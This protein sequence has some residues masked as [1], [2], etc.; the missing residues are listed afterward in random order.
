MQIVTLIIHLILC[1]LFVITFDGREIGAA[2]A[3][4]ITYILNMLGLEIYCCF[5]KSVKET[6]T[7]GPDRRAF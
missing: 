1:Y 4:N 3:T 6:Y 7:G 2:L 5:S